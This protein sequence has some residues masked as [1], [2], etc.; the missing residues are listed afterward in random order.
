VGSN[1]VNGVINVITKD[2]KDT[3]GLLLAGGGGTEQHG[4]GT[5]RYGAALGSTVRARVYGRGSTAMRR[6]SPTAGMPRTTGTWGRVGSTWIGRVE[7][8]PRHPAGRSVRWP[9]R[10]DQ[11]ATSPSADAT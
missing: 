3:Q 11:A 4:F 7:R 2:A 9:H 10:Q 8:K 5:V 1:A 6:R